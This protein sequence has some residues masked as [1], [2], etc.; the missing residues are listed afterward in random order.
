MEKL[1]YISPLL[2]IYDIELEDV[3]STSLGGN[4]SPTSIVSTENNP[5]VYK[6]EFGNS[7]A[8]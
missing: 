8:E 2:N 6:N 3:I 4:P 7:F 5:S 1:N